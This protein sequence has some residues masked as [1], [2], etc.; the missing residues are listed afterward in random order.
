[1]EESTESQTKDELER[2]KLRLEIALLK[3]QKGVVRYFFEKIFPALFTLIITVGSFSYALV[4]GVFD[5]KYQNLQL[6]KNQLQL[7]IVGFEIAR[8]DII[9]ENKML[10]NQSDSLGS[11]VNGQKDSIQSLTKNVTSL[12]KNL[13]SLTRIITNK[14][15]EVNQLAYRAGFL[16]NKIQAINSETKEDKYWRNVAESQL[17]FAKDSIKMF[18]DSNKVLRDSLKLLLNQKK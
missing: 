16:V 7:D 8:E 13:T 14:E 3:K 17:L 5:K 6:E 15:S 4:N 10:S 18:K 9:L 2:E 1:M 12:T 11:V